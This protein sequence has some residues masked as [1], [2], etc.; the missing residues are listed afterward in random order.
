MDPEAC[1]VWQNLKTARSS[2]CVPTSPWYPAGAP[3]ARRLS[4]L[5]CSL[6]SSLSF[7]L[8]LGKRA[9]RGIC[10]FQMR[11]EVDARKCTRHV[12]SPPGVPFGIHCEAS[13]G[14][15]ALFITV[16]VRLSAVTGFSLSRHA[17]WTEAQPDRV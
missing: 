8:C 2:E 11:R 6:R 5:I 1:K 17:L 3:R 12:T 13:L 15:S 16:V 14:A 7:F 9:G 10:D 4:R